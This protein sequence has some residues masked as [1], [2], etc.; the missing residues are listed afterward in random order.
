[1]S[2]DEVP[3]S[4]EFS[5]CR[6]VHFRGRLPRPIAMPAVEVVGDAG[7][8]GAGAEEEGGLDAQGG[9]VVEEVLPPVAGDALGQDHGQGVVGA[10]LEP[11]APSAR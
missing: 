2:T 9:L 11:A 8:D 7:D 6:G 4:C 5:L 1:M 3:I 10:E